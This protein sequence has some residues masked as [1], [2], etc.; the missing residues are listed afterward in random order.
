MHNWIYTSKC[1][2]EADI[3]ECK[4]VSVSRSADSGRSQLWLVWEDI[5]NIYYVTP[6]LASTSLHQPHSTPQ[7]GI[8]LNMQIARW[9]GSLRGALMR[10]DES[11][12]HQTRH[13]SHHGPCNTFIPTTSSGILQHWK[14]LLE[15]YW[16]YLLYPVV[17][18]F[19]LLLSCSFG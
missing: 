15:C 12:P 11:W 4:S 5:T 9:P 1:S 8:L 14:L 10:D 18:H 7:T 16:Y 13:C 17:C 2:D 19:H 3:L 6:P